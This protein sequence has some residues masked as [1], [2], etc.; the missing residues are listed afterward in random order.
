MSEL[1][2]RLKQARMEKGYSLEDL[3]EITKIQKRYLAAIE[4]GKFGIM[5]GTFYVRAF[6]KQYAEAVGLEADEML[7]MYKA[8]A[9]EP[10]VTEGSPGMSAPVMRRT[11]MRRAGKAAEMM[12]KI[13]LALFIVMAVGIVWF[14]KANQAAD[15]D[16]AEEVNETESTVQVEQIGPEDAEKAAPAEDDESS[17]KDESAGKSDAS[18]EEEESEEPEAALAV[19][20]S[21]GENTFYNLTG[22]DKASITLTGKGRSWVSVTD[23][24][25]KQYLS[26]SLEDGQKE[27]I[28]AEGI[29]WLRFRIGYVPGV[30]ISVNGNQLEYAIP[31]SER[32]TQNIIIQFGTAQ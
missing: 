16:P 18:E 1:G 24:S 23:N 9:P 4:E 7:A 8:E 6:I 25:G 12:P 27:T 26:K 3:Q 14:L 20:R 2:A 30:E 19:D 31:G 17:G 5:P 21:E 29:Q 32:V 22:T 15:T 13:I 10:L 28:E 11:S